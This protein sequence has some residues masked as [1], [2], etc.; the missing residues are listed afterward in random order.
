MASR[1]TD[2]NWRI[3]VHH[4]VVP[5]QFVDDSM[6]IKVPDIETQLQSMDNWHIRT[7][8]TSLTPRVFLKNMHRLREVARV[9]N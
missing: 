3:D 1:K 6:P 5:P 2:G 8:I 4:H 9:C 7:A